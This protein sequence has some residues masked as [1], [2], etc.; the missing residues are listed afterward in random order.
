VPKCDVCF[1]F[2]RLR[3]RRAVRSN[4]EQ[5]L[6]RCLWVDFYSFSPF[7]EVIALPDTLEV[8]SSVAKWRHNF[9]EIAVKNAKSLKV[10]GGKVCAPNFV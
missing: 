3:V 9:R 7:S 2:V 10:G 4:F 1:L 5:P 6:C 8:L